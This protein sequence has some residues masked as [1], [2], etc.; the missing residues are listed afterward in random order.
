MIPRA[1]GGNREESNLVVACQNCN[2]DKGYDEI[3]FEDLC[4]F[5]INDTDE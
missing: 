4:Q 3:I 2:S 1:Q 5:Y